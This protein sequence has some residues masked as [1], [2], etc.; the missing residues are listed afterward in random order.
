MNFKNQLI[1]RIKGRVLNWFIFK[2][3]IL[4]DREHTMPEFLNEDIC[5]ESM[6][7]NKGEKNENN[8]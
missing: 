1:V 4:D 6:T 5:Y 2:V 3:E 8:L 7:D